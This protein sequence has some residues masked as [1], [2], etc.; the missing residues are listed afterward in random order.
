MQITKVMLGL[1]VNFSW[2]RIPLDVASMVNES[3]SYARG[4]KNQDGGFTT[5]IVK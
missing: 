4:S 3:G 2:G 5:V 1:R